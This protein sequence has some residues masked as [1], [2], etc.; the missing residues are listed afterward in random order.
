MWAG[1]LAA[2]LALPVWGQEPP[3]DEK[4]TEAAK[5][6]VGP[7][8]PPHQGPTHKSGYGQRA[9]FG[10]PNSAEVQIEEDDRVK[11]PAFRFGA[12]DRVME[13]WFAW[14]KGLNEKTGL[15][16]S[17]H[18]VS[19]AQHLSSTLTDEDNAWSGLVRATFKWGVVGEGTSDAGSLVVMMD[20]RHNFTKLA[21]PA[22][23]S[24]A[25]Y[26]GQT[27]VLVNDVN[28]VF[29]NINWQ[30]G[31]RDGYAGWI[32][33]RFDP[34]DYINVLGVANP[35][36]GFQNLAIVLDASIAF[37]D[38]SYGVGGGN[39]FD[40]SWYV[41]GTLN[42]ANGTM[43]DYTFFEGGSEFFK[44]GEIGWSPT[45]ADRYTKNANLTFWHVDE[46]QEAGIDSAHGLAFAA[47][48]TFG[49]RLTPFFRLGWSE[50]TA[51]IYNRSV[52]A[53]LLYALA[54]R[55]DQVGL[56]VNWGDPPDESLKEQ[57]TVE[58]FYRWQF[59]QNLALTADLQV[60]IDP[61]LNPEKDQLWVLG[62]RARFTF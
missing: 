51:P 11:D 38:T 15:Q 17:G 48:W 31:F 57:I 59:A 61:A 3:A 9:T 2:G 26:I 40:D 29:P 37:P 52:T 44:A 45:K 16:L 24:Q 36:T 27:A 14:K 56:A 20:H 8:P 1:L 25:G 23:G 28:L 13:P 46:R 30:Q 42:D 50:G 54:R 49:E 60:L 34:N 62:V 47:N 22:L 5:S 33:G 10:G 32:V 19:L 21:P 7:P 4:P 58:G 43:A 53:G 55:S 12:F 41:L 35:W 39:Y 18:Y 6:A